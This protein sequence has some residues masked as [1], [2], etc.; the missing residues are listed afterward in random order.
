MRKKALQ[1]LEVLELQL[2]IEWRRWRGDVGASTVR[3]RDRT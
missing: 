1:P 3:V 2:V